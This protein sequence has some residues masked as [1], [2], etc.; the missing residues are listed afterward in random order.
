MREEEEGERGDG[1][2]CWVIGSSWLTRFFTSFVIVSNR[3]KYFDM[4]ESLNCSSAVRVL[5]LLLAAEG[6]AETEL[7]SIGL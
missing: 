3:V 2:D 4:V 5:L 7:I 1:A 6:M